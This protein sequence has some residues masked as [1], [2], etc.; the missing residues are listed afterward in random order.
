[1]KFIIMV[2]GI[3]GAAQAGFDNRKS[4]LH[5]MIKAAQQRRAS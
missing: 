1:M 4:R 5:D 2:V 3:L